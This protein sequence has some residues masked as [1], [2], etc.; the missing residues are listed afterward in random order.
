L[1]T[2]NQFR[3]RL[4]SVAAEMV[5]QRLNELP[6][7]DPGRSREMPF[8]LVMTPVRM[9]TGRRET[10]QETKEEDGD[11]FIRRVQNRL[12]DVRGLAL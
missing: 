1:S 4:D 9:S 6:R 8:E 12:A 7:G 10:K 3:K 11:D 2:I 5:L